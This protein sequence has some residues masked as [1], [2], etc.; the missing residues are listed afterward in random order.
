MNHS[1]LTAPLLGLSFL[2]LTAGCTVHETVVRGER[3]ADRVEVVPERPSPRHQWV[4]GRWESRGGGW[5]WV[6][7]RWEIS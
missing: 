2:A 6:G 3:P 1:R 5:E 7:G 4:A